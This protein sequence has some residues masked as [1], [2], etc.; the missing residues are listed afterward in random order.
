MN[1]KVLSSL[2]DKIKGVKE[3][4]KL[5]DDD[6]YVFLDIN[7]DDAFHMRGVGFPISIAF[8]NRD[9]EILNI[10]DMEPTTGTAKAP[11][12]TVYAVETQK[13]YF[14][15]NKLKVGD[16]WEKLYRH[17]NYNQ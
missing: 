5:N 8:L 16:G 1:I 2:S 4:E 17:M 9:F 14:D 11:E 6:V 3:L 12:N 10:T 7:E 15:K 13:G